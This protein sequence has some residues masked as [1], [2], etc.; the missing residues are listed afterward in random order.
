MWSEL[1][2]EIV[3]TKIMNKISKIIVGKKDSIVAGCAFDKLSNYR[4]LKVKI[5]QFLSSLWG[6]QISWESAHEGGKF[7]VD[8]GRLYPPRNILGTHFC[9]R[10]SRPQGHR[11]T[12]RS[13][14]MNNSN[15]DIGKRIR[16]LP[17]CSTVPQASAPPRVPL[18]DIAVDT[19]GNEQRQTKYTPVPTVRDT[20][21]MCWKR[22]FLWRW[23]TSNCIQGV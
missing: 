9:Q 20:R 13:I 7:F 22:A 4:M 11:A 10:L 14:S 2:K 1:V 8:T 15:D 21:S 3:R 5:N 16:D 19:I 18:T 17:A 12:G 23:S 6:S